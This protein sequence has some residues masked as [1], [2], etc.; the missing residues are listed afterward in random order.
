MNF[1]KAKLDALPLPAEG[2]RVT[3]HDE[4]GPQSVNGLSIRV[5]STGA[6]TFCVFRRVAG[7][8]A[9]R[10]T[11]GRYPALSIEQARKLAQVQIAKLAQGASPNEAKREARVASMTLAEALADYTSK[12]RRR[13]GLP[14]KQRTINDYLAMVKPGRVKLDGTR[15]QDGFLFALATTPIRRITAA[16]IRKLHAANLQHSERQSAYAMQVLRAV[17]NW[18]GIEV[19]HSPFGKVAGVAGKDRIVIP[20]PRASG[21]VITAEQIGPLWRAL[22]AAE[23]PVADYL[24]FLL[25][26]GCRPAEPL[27]VRVGDC[28]LAGG[29]VLLLDTK[30]RKDHTLHLSQQ[31]L[32]IV[33]KHAQG[34]APTARL[35]DIPDARRSVRLIAN[36]SGIAFSQKMLRATF[37]SIAESLVSAYTLKRMMNHANAGD[38]TGTHYVHKSEAELRA[39]WQV[40]ADFIETAAATNVL[41]LRA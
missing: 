34:K 5:T 30:N 38:V 9:E 18:H 6:K 41:Q 32:A 27:K 20:P 19:S 23:G 33:R 25:L 40:V 13:D 7:G 28:D 21:K 39:G 29:R 4:G 16:D 12:K 36:E 14:L 3:F 17:L 35:F 31:A 15:T 24:Q 10:V 26:T 11:L 22:A 2:K 8:K 1:T 37:A